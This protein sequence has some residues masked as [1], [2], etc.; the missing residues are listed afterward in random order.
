M[1]ACVQDWRPDIPPSCPSGYAELMVSCWDGEPTQRPSAQQLLRRLQTLQG[2]ARQ[3][4]VAARK[5]RTAAGSAAPA[6]PGYAAGLEASES[7]AAVAAQ[8]LRQLRMLAAGADAA[9]DGAAGADATVATLPVSGRVCQ[10]RQPLQHADALLTPPPAAQPARLSSPF[11]GSS[12]A[13]A[14]AEAMTPP[15]AGAIHTSDPATQQ[16]QMQIQI[17]Q[18]Q[19]KVQ[20]SWTPEG[21]TSMA[22]E[23]LQVVQSALQHGQLEQLLVTPQ[24]YEERQAQAAGSTAG[25]AAAGHMTDLSAVHL[26][27]LGWVQQHTGSPAGAPAGA[28]AGAFCGRAPYAGVL[29]SMA[30]AQQQQQ[31]H[32]RTAVTNLPPVDVVGFVS[33]YG[34]EFAGCLVDFNS[35]ADIDPDSTMAAYLAALDAAAVSKAA[36]GQG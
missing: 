20:D 30:D 2:Q 17:Q 18:Q 33:P 35:G 6:Q 7:E 11:A 16:Q 13:A 19:Q 28:G 9:V 10:E 29:P 5:A 25:S 26:Q 31:L 34:N 12:N 36:G 3:E 1:A 21:S 4:A 15:D 24:Q 23:Q 8:H 27:T 14:V 22:E 32:W